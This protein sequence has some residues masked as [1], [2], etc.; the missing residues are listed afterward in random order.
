MKNLSLFSIL[1]LL[2]G[3]AL[4]VA[5]FLIW[6]PQWPS[7]ILALNIVVASAVWIALT[8]GMLSPLFSSTPGADG[9]LPGLGLRG[10]TVTIYTILALTGMVVMNRGEMT[11]FRYQALYQAAVFLLMLCGILFSVFTSQRAAETE[12]VYSRQR[13]GVEDMRAATEGAIRLARHNHASEQVIAELEQMLGELRF[14]SPAS[15]HYADEL[16]DHY[17]ALVNSLST[18]VG[19]P[20][21]E[22]RVAETIAEARSDLRSRKAIRL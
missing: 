4:L 17:C 8:A 1:L 18:M 7:D 2:G 10:A 12:D 21:A 3:E 16:E 20:G 9:S 11:V 19:L 5:A 13:G 22:K 6:F 14:I 15:T